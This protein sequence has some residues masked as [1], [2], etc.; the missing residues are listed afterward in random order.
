[1]GTNFLNQSFSI[2]TAQRFAILEPYGGLYITD[3]YSA[4][5]KL[6]IHVGVRWDLPGGFSEKN[7]L[8]TVLQP[9]IASPLGS[10]LN[11]VTG[12]NQALTGNL[13]LVNSSQYP[14]KYDN[15]SHHHLFAPNLGLTYRLFPKTVIRT[16]YSLTYVAYDTGDP[17]A[18]GTPINSRNTVGTGPLSN[19]FPV[20]AGVLP[21]PLGRSPAYSPAIQGLAIAG[22]VTTVPYGYSQQWNFGI[23]D[24]LTKNSVLEVGYVG[25]AG[26]HLPITLNLNAVSD[27]VAAQAAAQYQSLVASGDAT[28]ANDTFLN[29]K[30][31]NPLAGMLAPTSIYNGATVA[32]GQLLRPHPQ[33]GNVSDTSYNEGA[34]IYHSLQASY[35][36]R[37][38]SAG[39]VF[40]SYSWSK[41]L[42]TIDTN[43]GFLET[44]SVGGY[45]D[46]NNLAG[47]RSLESFDVPQRLVLNYSLT[48]PFGRGK[49]WLGNAGPVVD[50]V[51]SGWSASSIT[52]FQKG[53]PLAFTTNQV[54][55]L[56][57]SFGFGGIRPNLVSGC[58]RNVSGSTISRLSGWFNTA[59]FTAPSTPFSTGNESRTDSALRTQGV[60]NWDF[61][62]TKDTALNERFHLLFTAQ[63]L[64]IF[65]RVQ[66]GQPNTQQ[67]NGLFGKVTSQ[68]NNPRQIQFGL[69]LSF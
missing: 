30:V 2:A 36:L 14:S 58:N 8:D 64:N 46:P 48:L 24:E 42:G 63:F 54:N 65:N 17:S 41:L 34:S 29:K 19:P 27:A 52:T 69:R 18:L 67:G 1:M 4:T 20:L 49:R 66:F 59:C 16:G 33:F 10:I 21:Q 62:L 7:D 3:T 6:T 44:N 53:F 43:V 56:S 50:R 38:K 32:Q 5:P 45:Q 40:L 13:V 68:I 57:S 55:F 26:T 11:P 51:V 47:Q 31:T 22:R 39:N 28:A 25:S 60:N 35:R 9:N 61:A 15:S 12:A 23:E 37:L